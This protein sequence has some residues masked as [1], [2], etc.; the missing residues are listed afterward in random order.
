MQKSARKEAPLPQ[1]KR[2]IK[3]KINRNAYFAFYLYMIIALLAVFTMS[4]YTWFSLSR[5]PRVN[6][7]NVYIT[8]GSGLELSKTPD[9]ND[10]VQELLFLDLIPKMIDYN[11]GKFKVNAKLRPATWSDQDGCLY[12]AKYGVD[13]RH[14]EY[15]ELND[16]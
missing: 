16:G 9:E 2:Y 4:S 10:W 14:Y 15:E 7:M 5:A 6:N 8:T 1:K 11:E 13:G 12:E 3:K